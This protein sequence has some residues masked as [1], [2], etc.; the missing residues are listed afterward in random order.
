MSTI[1]PRRIDVASS[2]RNPAQPQHPV[3]GP[4]SWLGET[5]KLSSMAIWARS[6]AVALSVE[7]RAI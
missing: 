2:W 6:V 4:Q 3:S 1:K 5:F 7:G